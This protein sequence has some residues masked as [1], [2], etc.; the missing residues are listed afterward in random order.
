MVC[1][2]SGRHLGAV[3]EHA[4]EARDAGQ[5]VGEQRTLPGTDVDHAFEPGHVG[6]LD[7]RLCLGAPAPGHLPVEPRELGG[8]AGS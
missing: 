2:P 8:A 4:A 7:Q 5:Q 1:L 3:G 6:A